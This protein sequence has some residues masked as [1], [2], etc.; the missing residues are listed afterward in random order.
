[1]ALWPT[2]L[3][4]PVEA[5]RTAF[6]I[7]ALLWVALCTLNA[8]ES[9]LSSPQSSRRPRGS[10]RRFAEL[11]AALAVALLLRA[12]VVLAAGLIAL[13]LIARAG[14]EARWPALR[15]AVVAGC[16][17]LA[18]LVPWV[19]RTTLSLGHPLLT[20]TTGLNLFRGNGPTA[21][22]GSYG[23]DGTPVWS[24]PEIDAE[25]AAVS[26]PGAGKDEDLEVRIDRVYSRHLGEYRREHP[27]AFL[28]VLPAK[29]LFFAVAD[30]THPKGRLAVVWGPWVLLLPF[31]IAGMVYGWKRRDAAWPLFFWVGFYVLIV[32]V[33][34]ALPRY[35]IGVEAFFLIFAARGLV[36]AWAAVAG[37]VSISRIPSGPRAA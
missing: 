5:E 24:T 21:S 15:G 2:F 26:Q 6:V 31:T 16:V 18:V 34:F 37:R 10:L 11:G 14:K 7:P 4:V 32:L 27:W 30:L 12:E 19:V 23:W 22:G 8:R 17:C 28:R 25:I 3:Y 9:L 1:M 20:T 29:F 33:F 35:R 36:A 13:L